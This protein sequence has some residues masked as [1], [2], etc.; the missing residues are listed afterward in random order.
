MKVKNIAVESL[1]VVPVII[2]EFAFKTCQDDNQ[3][4]RELRK[5]Q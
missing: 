3:F 2:S 1:G 4:G 5:E